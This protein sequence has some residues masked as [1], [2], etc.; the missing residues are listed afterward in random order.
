MSKFLQINCTVH[1]Y[2]FLP[3]FYY[4][5]GIALERRCCVRICHAHHTG[6]SVVEARWCPL[7]RSLRET[8]DKFSCEKIT[9]P[10]E[11][12]EP[13]GENYP[14]ISPCLRSLPYFL[15]IA[16]FTGFSCHV[17]SQIYICTVIAPISFSYSSSERRVEIQITNLECA[18]GGE[19]PVNWF[20]FCYDD[21]TTLRVCCS[22]SLSGM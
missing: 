1:D 10:H 21:S 6:S 2:K 9:P 15:P 4:L 20:Q 11:R 22:G 8:A 17:N 16:G 19:Y 7:C 13:W 12:R 5:E 18:L 3:F 14:F